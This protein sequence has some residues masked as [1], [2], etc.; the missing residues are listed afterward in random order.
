MKTVEKEFNMGTNNNFSR[1][2]KI[3][4]HVHTP[5]STDFADKKPE[6]KKISPVDYI[7]AV[8]KA[9]L[10]AV[11]LTDHNHCGWFEEIRAA[12]EKILLNRSEYPWYRDVVFFPGF[13]ITINPGTGRIHVLAVF[14]PSTTQNSVLAT[15]GRCGVRENH[16]DAEKAFTSQGVPDVVEEVVNA[17][18]IPILAHID[19][20]KGFFFEKTSVSSDMEKL[21]EN[22]HVVEI[23][24]KGSFKDSKGKETECGKLIKEHFVSVFGSDAHLVEDLGTRSTWVKMSSPTIDALKLALLDGDLSVKCGDEP[25][26]NR[27]PNAY[28]QELTVSK[29]KT[30]GR[31]PG[32]PLVIHFSPQLTSFI[33]GRGTGKSTV[34]ECIR[35]VVGRGGDSAG[36]DRCPDEIKGFYEKVLLGDSKIELTFKKDGVDY[37]VSW[38][39]KNDG[40]DE[41]ILKKLD[42]EEWVPVESGTI[43]NRIPISV[44]SQK[45]LN[46]LANE[47]STL[48]SIIDESS[49]VA[50]DEKDR[51]ILTTREN[52]IDLCKK[53]RD[54]QE[55]LKREGELKAACADLDAKLKNFAN[56]GYG[57]DLKCYSERLKQYEALKPPVSVADAM[58]EVAAVIDGVDVP[59]LDSEPFVDEQ[60]LLA[61]CSELHLAMKSAITSALGSIKTE[62]AKVEV[63]IEAYKNGMKASKW[64]K[65]YSEAVGRH[66]TIVEDLTAQEGGVFKENCYDDWI[67]RRAN[68]EAELKDL[69]RTRKEIE[70]YNTG[71]K[72]S[73]D[74]LVQ[75]RKSLADDRNKF[76]ENIVGDNKYVRMKC[77]PFADVRKMES[78][79]R[80]IFSLGESVFADVLYSAEEK[81]GL[82][83]EVYAA[84][85]KASECPDCDNTTEIL[86]AVQKLKDEIC[87]VLRGKVVGDARFGKRLQSNCAMYPDMLYKF[88]SWFPDDR[89]NIKYWR[90][91]SAAKFVSMDEGGSAG[92]KAAAILAF[93]L[94][95]GDG[96]LV[97]DQPEDDLDNSLIYDL[98]IKQ[99]CENKG[100]RQLVVATH[101]SN[102]VVN[103]DSELVNVMG[104]NN[105]QIKVKAK[106]GMGESA[107]R[108]EICS[109]MEGGQEALHHRYQRL[110]GCC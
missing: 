31:I 97:I 89:L 1:W 72:E 47:Q 98:V 101:N 44:F 81:T 9:R 82:F 60:E 37:S 61:E 104:M 11:V 18:G 65:K 6:E 94:S 107:I 27:F 69:D 35:K 4:F 50:K 59:S 40:E 54:L 64:A 49:V 66:N 19:A 88:L 22:V 51:L 24:E 39:K 41:F 63:A 52:Y 96:I 110:S 14:D 26:P 62:I 75:A 87:A 92:Q 12:Q 79:F 106:G 28:L 20:N 103:G 90:G 58:R 57:A 73:F 86:D 38:S 3:D 108:T 84:A 74:S 5:K 80:M 32:D 105:G 15:L 7:K 93:L 16:G 46:K 70:V 30:A 45:Q 109:I 68:Y 78:D 43:I 2:W 29:V 55:R 85:K 53:Q 83:A 23:Q 91:D 99:I 21:V 17:K 36:I 102:V 33:G 25:D 48:M 76:I 10:D 71:I 42:G 13:E 56:K 8:V 95:H 34:V 77:I 100:K 67:K